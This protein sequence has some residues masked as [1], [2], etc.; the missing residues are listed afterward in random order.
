M[1]T[2]NN[3]RSLQVKAGEFYP[4]HFSRRFADKEIDDILK[5][6]GTRRV[7]ADFQQEKGMKLAVAKKPPSKLQQHQSKF[8]TSLMIALAL[9]AGFL[10]KGII[11]AKTQKD[12]AQRAEERFFEGNRLRTERTDVSLD[13]VEGK[14]IFTY[15]V[16]F[17]Y[18][19]IEAMYK[20]PSANKKEI[21]L[22]LLQ[23]LGRTDINKYLLSGNV[24]AL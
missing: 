21:K 10:G 1:I 15:R 5:Q 11:D 3:G 16:D 20:I 14:E 2:L 18:S 24:G 19:Y 4:V 23:Y 13:T 12:R 17:Y 8:R 22:L 9:G 6:S 7:K